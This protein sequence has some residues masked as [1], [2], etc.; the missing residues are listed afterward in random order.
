MARK[1]K[2]AIDPTVQRYLEMVQEIR[3]ATREI[4]KFKSS[5]D[6]FLDF[7]EIDLST[8]SPSQLAFESYKLFAASRATEDNIQVWGPT[9]YKGTIESAELKQIQS[10]INEAL[11]ALFLE[12]DAGIWTYPGPAKI[13]VMRVAS[14]NEKSHTIDAILGAGDKVR[15]LIHGFIQALVHGAN[16]L[17]TCTRCNKPFVGNKRQ[18]YCTANCSQLARNEKKKTIKE[19]KNKK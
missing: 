12:R 17:R 15:F 5:L 19:S 7:A 2:Q 14:E 10:T 16:A 6:W 4:Q 13:I 11:K 18:E 1:P 9:L 3:S 8:L